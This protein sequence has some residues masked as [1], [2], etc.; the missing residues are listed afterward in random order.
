MQN[1]RTRLSTDGSRLGRELLG[2]LSIF[3]GLL[4]ILSLATFDNRD[5]WLNHVVSGATRIHNK[6]GLF[7]AYLAGL[8][9]DIVGAAS[10]AVPAFLCLAGV[11]R[12]I[13]AASSWPWWRWTGFALLGLSLCL[14]GAAGD[15]GDVEI[16][17]R[18]ILPPGAGNVS[19]HGGGIIGHMLYVG[20][21]GWM[22]PVGAFLV[23]L[24]SLILALQM[25]SGLSV[26]LLAAVG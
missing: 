12:V 3:L 13:G 1:E 17:A 23:W 19:S 8:L 26:R 11:R 15:L 14:A 20:I 9:L 21:V 16:F 4:V 5:P 6:A 22:S 25:L 10:W 24:F 7:G 18:G 2:L